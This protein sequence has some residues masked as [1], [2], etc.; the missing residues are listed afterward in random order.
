MIV[1]SAVVLVAFTPWMYW[2]GKYIY[3]KG[4]LGSNLE[5]IQKPDAGA[6]AWFFVDLAG[7]GDFPSIGRQ[8]VTGWC[9]WCSPPDTPP[10][11]ERAQTARRALRLYGAL[12]AVFRAGIGGRGV[13]R[14]AL[15]ADSVWGHRHMVY[16][17]F[18]MLMLVAAAYYPVEFGCGP[19]HRRSPLRGLGRHGDSAPPEGRRQEDSLRLRWSSRCSRWRP[20]T[21]LR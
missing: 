19:D 13:Y 15:A 20:T 7:F 4:G 5:W 9:C 11:C 14:L 18:P 8:A 1:S 21:R 12:P 2:V 6:L 10:G 3:A 16:L 17:V